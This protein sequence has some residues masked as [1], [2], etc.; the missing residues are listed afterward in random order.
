[1]QR[2]ELE[3]LSKAELIEADLRDVMAAGGIML[4]RHAR[5][6]NGLA[7]AGLLT[8][9]PCTNA[10]REEWRCLVVEPAPML[11]QSDTTAPPSGCPSSRSFISRRRP[12]PQQRRQCRVAVAMN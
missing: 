9:A 6:R 1:M 2:D 8:P 12:P 5:E 4:G 7:V 10:R 11:L 3:R